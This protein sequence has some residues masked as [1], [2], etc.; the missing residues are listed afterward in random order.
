MEQA[1]KLRKREQ[2]TIKSSLNTNLKTSKFSVNLLNVQG[3]TQDKIVEIDEKMTSNMLFCLV[4]TQLTRKKFRRRNYMREITKMRKLDDKKGGGL[5]ITWKED[6][7][8]TVE[9]IITDHDDILA[10][11]TDVCKIKFNI[12]LVYMA[13]KDDS[14]NDARYIP[15]GL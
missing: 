12:I 3:L 15:R 2:K 13:T 14:R 5:M 4:E 1:Q 11:R 10:V 7:G 8:I 6:P 9:E